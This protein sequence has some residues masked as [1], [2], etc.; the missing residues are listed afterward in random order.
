MQESKLPILPQS[1]Q[2]KIFHLHIRWLQVRHETT[3]WLHQQKPGL[4]HHM[5]EQYQTVCRRNQKGIQ[6]QN[7]GA[8]TGYTCQKR[9]TSIHTFQWTWPFIWKHDIP[10]HTNTPN[11]SWRWHIHNQ[12][13]YL[14]KILDLS[15]QLTQTL[16]SQCVWIRHQQTS[17]TFPKFE[18]WLG[19]FVIFQGIQTSIAKK[20]RKR[21][22]IRNRCNQVPHLI[23]NTNGKVTNSP[24][25]ITNESQEVSPF[26]GGEALYFCNFSG[27][28]VWTPVPPPPLDSPM[29]CLFVWFDSLH[30]INN[31]SVI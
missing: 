4:S 18:C 13:S 28:G 10:N 6:I 25:D 12:T 27:G 7:G 9:N 11:G 24:L 21:A 23:Q 22:K 19:S 1:E 8:Y 30:P 20:V 5:H 2:I 26:A 29:F 14:Q 17:V 15:A 3:W 31:R 16:G